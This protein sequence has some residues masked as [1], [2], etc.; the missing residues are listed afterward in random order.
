[1][2]TFLGRGM[3]SLDEFSDTFQCTALLSLASE[4]DMVWS[5]GLAQSTVRTPA[6]KSKGRE[7]CWFRLEFGCR[8][9]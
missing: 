4:S 2:V 8:N 1:M 7:T 3:A 5:T 9:Y 6:G